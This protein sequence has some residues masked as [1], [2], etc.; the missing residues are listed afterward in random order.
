MRTRSFIYR[1]ASSKK[2]YAT[3]SAPRGLSLE[4][5]STES[6]ARNGIT[7]HLPLA[8]LIFQWP[9]VDGTRRRIMRAMIISA[10]P[11]RVDNPSI[12]KRIFQ[13]DES[14]SPFR[15]QEL[16]IQV[17]VFVICRAQ[18]R[19]LPRDSLRRSRS[20]DAFHRSS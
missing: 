16:L 13:M 6:I 20:G 18:G 4:S 7:N 11:I 2:Q 1:I 17:G 8:T 19:G 5:T 14:A 10:R 15:V 12:G 3:I 9:L